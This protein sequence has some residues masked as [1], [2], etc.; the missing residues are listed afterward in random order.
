MSARTVWG[1]LVKLLRQGGADYRMLE[2]FYRAV[3]QAVLLL[4]RGL[5]DFWQKWRGR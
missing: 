5:G 1:R 3:A 2:M 4:A